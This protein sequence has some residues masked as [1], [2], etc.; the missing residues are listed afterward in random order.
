MLVKLTA[1]F[2]I[3]ATAISGFKEYESIVTGKN[4]SKMT[5]L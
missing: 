4:Q 1:G 5:S 2:F 3:C